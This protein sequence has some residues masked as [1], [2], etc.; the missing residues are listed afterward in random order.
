MI[1][2]ILFVIL[3]YLIY[4]IGKKFLQLLSPPKT[5]IKGNPSKNTRTFDQDQIEDIDYEEVD[6]KDDK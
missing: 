4:T 6:K 5:N 2:F 3:F 1:R